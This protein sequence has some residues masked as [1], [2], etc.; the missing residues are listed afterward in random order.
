M[1]I[2]NLHSLFLRINM[3]L[4]SFDF[5]WQKQVKGLIFSQTTNIFYKEM[6]LFDN[7]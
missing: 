5:P 4:L 6:Q 2:F 3:Q 1:K 7:M